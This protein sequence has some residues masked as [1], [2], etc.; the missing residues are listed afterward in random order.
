MTLHKTSFAWVIFVVEIQTFVYF[1]IT[2]Y[3]HIFLKSFVWYVC[4]CASKQTS[5]HVGAK[6]LFST[7]WVSATKASLNIN[8]KSARQFLVI[9]LLLMFSQ[10]KHPLTPGEF[11]SK[12]YHLELLNQSLI[13]KIA[14]YIYVKSTSDRISFLVHSFEF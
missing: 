13:T 8:V 2:L 4:V 6:Q 10:F 7:T 12:L 5:K 9:Y 3:R 1:H 11:D 14:Y